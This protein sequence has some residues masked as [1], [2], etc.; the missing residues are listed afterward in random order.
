MQVPDSMSGARW[1]S[2]RETSGVPTTTT[3]ADERP[4]SSGPWAAGA[5]QWQAVEPESV[6]VLPASGTNLQS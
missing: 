3:T 2:T 1:T 4:R 5:A 6:K